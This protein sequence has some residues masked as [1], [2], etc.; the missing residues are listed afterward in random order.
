MIS[1]TTA[2]VTG[3]NEK[4]TRPGCFRRFVSFFCRM[5][6]LTKRLFALADLEHLGNRHEAVPALTQTPDD[7]GKRLQRTLQVTAPA[8]APVLK[9]DGPSAGPGEDVM[10]DL[11]FGQSSPVERVD[12]PVH[13]LIAMRFRPLQLRLVDVAIRRTNQLRLV[14]G[15]QLQNILRPDNLDAEGIH[16]QLAELGVI[17]GVVADGM[18]F[19]DHPRHQGRV[20]LRTAADHEEGGFDFIFAQHIQELRCESRIRHIIEG[21]SDHFTAGTLR[22]EGLRVFAQQLA[23]ERPLFFLWRLTEDWEAADPAGTAVSSSIEA[24]VREGVRISC[25]GTGIGAGAPAGAAEAADTSSAAGEV[26]GR[27]RT[28]TDMSSTMRRNV[29]SFIGTMPPP[30]TGPVILEYKDCYFQAAVNLC[31]TGSRAFKDLSHLQIVVY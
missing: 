6:L 2:S 30:T 14:A 15:K 9:D 7:L 19:A 20:L 21:E 28:I 23:E 5:P 1:C 27:P 31:R 25:T 10:L 18:A 16:T 24:C 4:E 13:Q 17:I 26:T 3:I 22:L 8:A 29:A 11:I 12:V